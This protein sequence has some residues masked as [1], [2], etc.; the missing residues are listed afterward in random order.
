MVNEG[1]RCGRWVKRRREFC[2]GL[3]HSFLFIIES[4][5]AVTK[6]KFWVEETKILSS[7]ERGQISKKRDYIYGTNCEV[8]RIMP[9]KDK[10]RHTPNLEGTR[11]L[12]LDPRNT[13]TH[14]RR[15]VTSAT[16]LSKVQKRE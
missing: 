6:V 9:P 10:E 3:G 5:A 13:P 7:P 12:I 8:T 15:K 4:K 1:D 16:L 2:G 11:S 14:E